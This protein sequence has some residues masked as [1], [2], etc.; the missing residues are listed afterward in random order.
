MR[1]LYARFL[2]YEFS[3]CPDLLKYA[4]NFLSMQWIKFTVQFLLDSIHNIYHPK[5]VCVRA[6]AL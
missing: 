1:E 4:A 6:R 3:Q 5:N 2:D